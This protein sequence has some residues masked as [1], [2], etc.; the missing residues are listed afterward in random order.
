M[1]HQQEEFDLQKE[2]RKIVSNKGTHYHRLLEET[3]FRRLDKRE[4]KNTLRDK[5]ILCAISEE[6]SNPHDQIDC[7]TFLQMIEGI[8]ERHAMHGEKEAEA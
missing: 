5:G 4:L 6:S 7:K 3:K 8:V 2:F 1:D